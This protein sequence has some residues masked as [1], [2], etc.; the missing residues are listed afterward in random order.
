MSVIIDIDIDSPNESS[1]KFITPQSEKT[2]IEPI[3]R[4]AET[5]VENGL[6]S[7]DNDLWLHPFRIGNSK[8]ASQL[9]RLD[10]NSDER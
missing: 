4:H 2:T 3:Q 8:L 9:K 5:V 1:L 6:L 10:S 7:A